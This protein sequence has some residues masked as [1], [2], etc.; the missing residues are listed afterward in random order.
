MQ[1]DRRARG[2]GS[3]LSEAM[4]TD[5]SYV[6]VTIIGQDAARGP[7]SVAEVLGGAIRRRS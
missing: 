2:L 1:V 6:H 7:G 3:F 5:E 4:G